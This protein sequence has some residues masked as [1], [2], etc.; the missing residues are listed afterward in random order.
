MSTDRLR[1]SV[2]F[3]VRILLHVI[4]A[5][6]VAGKPDGPFHSFF[7]HKT[8]AALMELVGNYS[9]SSSSD[10]TEESAQLEPSNL[11]HNEYCSSDDVI[12]GCDKMAPE[13][14]KLFGPDF[15]SPARQP[16]AEEKV[17]IAKDSDSSHVLHQKGKLSVWV[18]PATERDKARRKIYQ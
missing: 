2:R 8:Q 13:K 15:A 9:S 14:P 16:S 18:V 5:F 4:N 12:S 10:D 7:L 17:R 1:P 11:G 3:F 6:F